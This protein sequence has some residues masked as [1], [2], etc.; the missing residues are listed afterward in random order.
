VQDFNIAKLKQTRASRK[1][2]TSEKEP[3]GPT[4][5]VGPQLCK[6]EENNN[7]QLTTNERT[8]E[9]PTTSEPVKNICIFNDD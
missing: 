9:R 1:Q 3:R 4:A 2:K 7:K 8:N 6:V 5:A